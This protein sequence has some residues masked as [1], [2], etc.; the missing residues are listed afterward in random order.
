MAKIVCSFRAAYFSS[1]LDYALK[2]TT[3]VIICQWLALVAF[4][5][6]TTTCSMSGTDWISSARPVGQ[7]FDNLEAN[8]QC[9]KLQGRHPSMR[10]DWS[11]FRA[12]RNAITCMRCLRCLRGI[13]QDRLLRD[14][15]SASV[16]QDERSA[17]HNLR[18]S[19]YRTMHAIT[20]NESSTLRQITLDK[21]FYRLVRFPIT[22][23][24]CNGSAVK[25]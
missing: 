13:V 20:E 11:L 19:C 23:S 17:W 9:L 16:E 14:A 21:R 6:R 24:T 22:E 7:S 10:N 18:G 1:A 4:L 15:V 3:P 8:G 25:V 5:G 12:C 2:P